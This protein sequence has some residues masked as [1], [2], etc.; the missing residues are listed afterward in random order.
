MVLPYFDYADIVIDKANK[1]E[2]DK[3]QR[4]QNRCIKICLLMNVRT[5][6]DYIHSTAKMPKLEARRKV[7]LRNFMYLQLCKPWLLDIKSVNTRLRDAPLFKVKIANTL[8][9]ERSVHHN[10]AIRWN[11]LPIEIRNVN[12]YL[13]FKLSQLRWL[14][15]TY[16]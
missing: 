2:L 3:L 6:T 14:H 7:H 13:S 5:D 10:G 4:A 16:I 1:T 11:N 9:Y 12:Q 15:T 8:A